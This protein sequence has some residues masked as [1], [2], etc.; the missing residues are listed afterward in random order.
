MFYKKTVEK[1]EGLL[2]FTIEDEEKCGKRSSTGKEDTIDPSNPPPGA[3]GTST[4]PHSSSG[5]SCTLQ[6]PPCHARRY[7][8]IAQNASRHIVC[9]AGERF[10][11]GAD[12]RSNTHIKS[13]LGPKILN[14]D[15]VVPRDLF[16]ESMSAARDRRQGGSQQARLAQLEAGLAGVDQT[17]QHSNQRGAGTPERA[18]YTNGGYQPAGVAGSRQTPSP[19]LGHHAHPAGGTVAVPPGGPLAAPS[20]VGFAAGGTG[21]HGYAAFHGPPQ[22]PGHSSDNH[23]PPGMTEQ[24]RVE[25]TESKCALTYNFSP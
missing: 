3:G 8:S 1:A 21:P 23:V 11:S 22:R 5:P 2:G 18:P 25:R 13:L 15:P 12:C 6:H 20:L 7:R 14:W 16:P 10:W 4:P 17:V 19:P 24:L 9:A